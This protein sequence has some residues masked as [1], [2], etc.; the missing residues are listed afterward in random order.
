MYDAVVIDAYDVEGNVPSTFTSADCGISWAA[1][2]YGSFQKSGAM[3]E[4]KKSRPQKGSYYEDTCKKDPQ[5]TETAIWCCCLGGY[6]YN[7]CGI[8]PAVNGR[9]MLVRARG[10]PA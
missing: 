6:L 10:Y 9:L 3:R 4:S 1:L 7:A 2:P 8:G 5:Y